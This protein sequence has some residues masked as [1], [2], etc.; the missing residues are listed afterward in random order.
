M[1]TLSE[2]FT[3][4]SNERTRYRDSEVRATI[5]RLESAAEAAMYKENEV[6]G[7]ARQVV[8]DVAVALGV[9]LGDTG[10]GMSVWSPANMRRVVAA[11]RALKE[12]RDELAAKHATTVDLLRVEHERANAAIERE[13]A[14][15][16][17]ATEIGQHAR[18]VERERDKYRKAAEEAD[19]KLRKIEHGCETPESHN[20]GCPCDEAIE[21]R[22]GSITLHPDPMTV[23]LRF[24]AGPWSSTAMFKEEADPAP[25]RQI[26]VHLDGSVWH[27]FL[28]AAATVDPGSRALREELAA[29]REAYESKPAVMR[30]EGPGAEW[31][32]EQVKEHD[33]LRATIVSQAREIA[34]LQGESA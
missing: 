28:R 1:R 3:A 18:R 15:D 22:G 17:A 26:G 29:L 33:E 25:V 24:D 2:L 9:V 13:E 12:E 11:A 7:Q 5:D 30:L 8:S 20:Y 6:G 27:E 16:E 14:A 23:D 10:P 4:F 32:A 34:R 31:L 21:F 19:D